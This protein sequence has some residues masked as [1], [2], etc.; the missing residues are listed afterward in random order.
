MMIIVFGIWLI[1]FTICFE[2]T[3]LLWIC[4]TEVSNY[5]ILMICVIGLSSIAMVLVLI[6]Q[7][8]TIGEEITM[9]SGFLIGAITGVVATIQQEKCSR[10]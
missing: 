6:I 5:Q 1:G 9:F 10:L 4:N 3:N 8:S 2:M 7:M